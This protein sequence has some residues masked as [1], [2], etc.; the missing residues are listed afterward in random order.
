MYP[1]FRLF[2]DMARARKMPK[3][4]LY[5][6]HVSHH[7]CLPWDL[8]LWNELNNGRTL[9]IYDLGRIPLAQ[10]SGLFDLLK[11][12]RWGLTIAGSVVRYRRRVQMFH[13]L[14]THS[15]LLGRDKRFLYIEQS[16][17]KTDG[18]CSS[19]AVFRAAITDRNGIVTTDRIFAA[20]QT[21]EPSPELPAW[22]QKWSE[23]EDLRPWP[24]QKHR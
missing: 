18:E 19:H 21:D 13:K 15:R 2:K 9:T 8:D 11:R 12:E 3:L 16:M 1:F 20:L 5:D 7:I 17:W 10:R 6:T 4:G 14:E 24:P 22:V 23:A